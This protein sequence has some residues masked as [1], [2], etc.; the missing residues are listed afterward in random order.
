M[1][2]ASLPIVWCAAK[3]GERFHGRRG[4]L[5]AGLFTAI[6]PDL[7]V[8]A[9]H[10]LEEVFAADV[11]VPAIYLVETCREGGQTARLVGRAGFLLGLAVML[12]LQ[13]AP[14]VAIAGIALCGR[15]FR[16]WQAAIIGA[17]M[18][19]LAF[20]LLDWFTWG[21]PF[22]SIWLNIYLNVFKDVAAQSFGASPAAYYIS[23]LGLDWL[24]SMPVMILLGWL[25]AK[26]LPLAGIVLVT[27]VATHSL[28]AHKEFRFIFPAIALLVP[29]AG[30]A[31]A[32]WLAALPNARRRVLAGLLLV[33]PVF[34]PWPLFLLSVETNSFQAF[35]YL[36]SQ[37]AASIAIG[38][39][40]GAFL[41]L[42]VLLSHGTL[43]NYVGA[44]QAQ[45]L[46]FGFIVALTGSLVPPPGYAVDRCYH[47]T[48]M[49]VRLGE[50]LPFCIW[51]R[52]VPA[53]PDQAAPPMAPFNIVFPAAAKPF[54]IPDR[55]GG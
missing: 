16:R 31:L 43:V 4:G 32:G 15:D 35:E 45:S 27:I 55:L 14:A 5:V 13:M 11:L 54:I 46:R 8:M 51:R 28:V 10:T 3:W 36:Q 21:E 48:L 47:G 41:P 38:K 6:W 26:R 49:T 22:R 52:I 29:L 23:V 25:G 37:Q 40:N 50:T 34:S 9:P 17:A 7:W 53:P 20:G 12:R 44:T 24:W 42:D 19:V 2:L 18:P 39:F 1:A 30:V 33:G